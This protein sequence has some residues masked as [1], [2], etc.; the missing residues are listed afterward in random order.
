[1]SFLNYMIDVASGFSKLR[2]LMRYS[3]NRSE[4]LQY[5]SYSLEDEVALA[6]SFTNSY[7]AGQEE[8]GG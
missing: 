4:G 8:G 1:M 5:S 7:P 2:T 6:L 3:A